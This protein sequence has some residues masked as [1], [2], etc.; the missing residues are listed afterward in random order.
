M[1]ERR[2]A[3]KTEDFAQAQ[4][5]YPHLS[6]YVESVT[7][8]M[9]EPDWHLELDR[10]MRDMD[11]P[12]LI[13]PVGDP[14]FIHIHKLQDTGTIRY[15]VI[16]PELNEEEEKLMEKVLDKMIEH[17]HKYP[18]PNKVEDA[19]EIIKEIYEEVVTVSERE[20]SS[21]ERLIESKVHLTQQEHDDIWYYIFRNR[22]G[23]GKLEPLF[24][25]PY[26]EDI[27]CTGVSNIK[28]VHKVFEMVHT[29]IEFK[30]DIE[31]NKYILDA[32]ERVERPVS[33]ANSARVSRA[34]QS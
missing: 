8:S 29:S 10:G 20:A 23:Y 7:A 33:D 31:L 34:C 26:L 22:V 13:Y 6:R 21:I 32:S 2:H 14:I 24:Y 28:T 25:D 11:N 27:H 5:K 9:G 12:N 19:G 18:V 15:E 4:A 1:V 30:D 16:Q 3:P 17:A